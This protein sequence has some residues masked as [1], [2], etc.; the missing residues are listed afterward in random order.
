MNHTSVNRGLMMSWAFDE[1][2]GTSTIE[3]V[4]QVRNEIQ[5][6][7]NQAEF[8]E[9]Q[10]PQWREGVMGSGLLFDGYSTYIAHTV[11]EG[12]KNMK[13]AYRDALSIGVWVAPRFYGWGSEGKLSAIVNN[14]DFDRKQGYLLGMFRH[15][16]WSFQVGL[17]GGA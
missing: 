14:H 7:F 8:N 10:E 2:T 17:E 16:S 9:P 3:N 15:G 13:Q 4:A 11:H 5:Y 1:G 12:N 6:V